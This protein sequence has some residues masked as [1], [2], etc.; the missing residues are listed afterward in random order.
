MY[1]LVNYVFLKQEHLSGK[2][3]EVLLFEL[4]IHPK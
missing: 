3:K 1:N 4:F 2:T